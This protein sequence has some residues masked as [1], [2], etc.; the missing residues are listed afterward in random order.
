MVQQFGDFAGQ[1]GLLVASLIAAMVY[2]ILGVLF[3]RYA[4][5]MLTARGLGKFESLL[6]LGIV[7]WLLF[8][9]V[10]FPLVGDSFFGIASP[11]ASASMI[12]VFPFALLLVVAALPLPVLAYL[13]SAR[14]RARVAGIEAP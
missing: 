9:L 13:W 11:F 10:L 1:I 7:P 12:W 6:A 8:G 14:T 3:D 4:V 5:K 2:G